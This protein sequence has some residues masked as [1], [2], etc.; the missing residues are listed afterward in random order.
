[1][2]GLY[3]FSHYGDKIKNLA[4]LTNALAVQSA[5]RGTDAT[6]IA[7]CDTSGVTIL[8]ENKSAYNLEFKHSDKISCLT[9]HTRHSTQGSEKFNKNNH[10][11]PGRCINS[12][13]A[14]SHNGVLSNDGELR[15]RFNL[16]K[17]KIETD[18]YVAVQLI[19]SKMFLSFDS[20]KFMA[21]QT[22]GS[23]SY[24]ILDD[25][26]NIW[27][28]KGDS[29]LSILHFPKLKIYVYASTDEILYRS[30]VDYAPLFS[31]L[32]KGE[33]KA[34]DISEGDIL[35]IRSDGVIE[36]DKF[37]YSYFC[38]KKWWDYGTFSY[39]SFC[40]EDDFSRYNYIEDLKA[41]ATYQGFLPDDIDELINAGFTLD[42]IEEYI[43]CS[44]GGE[45]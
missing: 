18:S 19:E 43:Y 39:T 26:N 21:E 28:V 14:L 25:E 35:K 33:F 31:A 40:E 34:V 20:I 4:D 17:T 2:C 6:G 3:G 24:S 23:F 32:K 36:R 8:K 22:E 42:E 37:E 9:G 7:F 30:L 11:F 41:V 27:L 16:P 15:K 12:K 38:G 29:P 1:M 10:P 13:F 44:C 45:I 5:I